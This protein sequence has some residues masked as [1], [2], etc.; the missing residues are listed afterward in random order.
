MPKNVVPAIRKLVY[1]GGEQNGFNPGELIPQN[2]KLPLGG[3]DKQMPLIPGNERSLRTVWSHYS[4][5]SPS[6]SGSVE[7]SLPGSKDNISKS[8]AWLQ[9]V[10]NNRTV[11]KSAGEERPALIKEAKCSSPALPINRLQGNNNLRFSVPTCAALRAVAGLAKPLPQRTDGPLWVTGR[12]QDSCRASLTATSHGFRLEAKNWMQRPRFLALCPD[13][14][15]LGRAR[16]KP[17]TSWHRITRSPNLGSPGAYP[18]NTHTLKLG[19]GR[20]VLL[21]SLPG[22]FDMLPPAGGP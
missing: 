12:G 5:T 22:S 17:V 15:A 21:Q 11:P 19:I 8:W 7:A 6:C 10:I 14:R 2:Q 20:A 18:E 3:D 4:A 16:K 13:N 1:E 9:K